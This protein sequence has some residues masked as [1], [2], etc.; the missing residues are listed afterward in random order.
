MKIAFVT[1]KLLYGGAER[2]MSLLANEMCRVGHKV[3]FI[4]IEP[5]KDCAYT[6]DKDISIRH[7]N[8]FSIKSFRNSLGLLLD[9]RKSIKAFKPDAIICF[10]PDSAVFSYIAQL[11]LSIPI[12]FSERNDPKNNI[13]GRLLRFFQSCA[14][15]FSKKIVFQTKGAQSY[16]GDRYRSKS[17]II[18]NPFNRSLLPDPHM[19][20]RKKVF[21]SVGRLEKQKNHRLLIDSFAMIAH[22]HKDYNLII[23]G[24]GN[25]RTDLEERITYHH[26]EQRVLLSGKI[27]DVFQKINDSSVFVFSSNYEGLPN[28]LIEAM[29]LGLPCVT[30]DCSPGGARE[31]IQN[32]VNGIIVPCND[33]V[34]LSRAM[35]YMIEHP[36]KAKRM[37]DEA[38][39][40]MD[41]LS[42]EII[43]QK[44]IDILK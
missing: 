25:L 28:A 16:Y 1:N 39:K 19:G 29:A 30:T 33:S 42:V 21:V 38:R 3:E 17:Y 12:I 11:G 8:G 14:L 10:M 18:L 34:E 43:T 23:Y 26:L 31:L 6:I 24:D 4:L 2:C 7:L 27:T 36:E 37:G 35:N 22:L 13:N 5:N 41:K 20:E 15:R 44:W 32:K 40:I 9:L